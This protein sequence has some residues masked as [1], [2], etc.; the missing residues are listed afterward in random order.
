MEDI[1]EA[2]VRMRREGRRGALATI[3]NVRG[4]VPSHETAR[5]LVF[6]DGSSVGTVGGGR[7]EAEVVEAARQVLA[8]E[9]PRTVSFDLN[10][11]STYD[12]GLVC[13]G[14]LDVFI[15]PIVPPLLV[16]VFGAGH[17]GLAVYKAARL[18]GFEVI[19]TDDRDAFANRER[20]PEARE[21]HAEPIDRVLEHLAPAPSAAIVICT[22]G[23]RHDLR[24]LRWAAMTPAGYVGMIGSR[25]KVLTVFRELEGDGV[26]RA[27]LAR[28]RAP[29]GLE[30]GSVT[31]EEIAISIVAELIAV[32]RGAPLGPSRTPREPEGANLPEGRKSALDPTRADDDGTPR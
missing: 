18:T 26:P 17:V 1:F 25:R 2:I 30:I 13:G 28:V 27:A 31:P 20:F 22:R 9:R 12:T 32:R 7:V 21:V 16:Y 23:H 6:E 19:V 11:D 5:M 4:S 14:S 8:T 10:S 29:I 24:V 3:V 15:E